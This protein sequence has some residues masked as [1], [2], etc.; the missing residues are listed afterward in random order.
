MDWFIMEDLSSNIISR[1]MIKTFMEQE[2][3]LNAVKGTKMRCQEDTLDQ[4][5]IIRM[6]LGLY[7][8]K[9]L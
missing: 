2:E 6:K 7:L 1:Q 4:I 9:S 8:L 5:N 3:S